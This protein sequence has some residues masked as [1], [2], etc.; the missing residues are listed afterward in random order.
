MSDKYDVSNDDYER[1][2]LYGRSGMSTPRRRL[3]GRDDI[4][5]HDYGLY[6]GEYQ[7]EDLRPGVSD[8]GRSSTNNNYTGYN[9]SRRNSAYSRADRPHDSESHALRRRSSNMDD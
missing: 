4:A 7:R 1:E 2:M 9:R 3:R 8:Y 6:G 5:R